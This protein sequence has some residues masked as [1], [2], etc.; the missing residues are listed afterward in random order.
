M[1]RLVPPCGD[2][3]SEVIDAYCASSLNTYIEACNEP[4]KSRLVGLSEELHL[5][6]RSYTAG[7][8]D[9]SQ[10]GR[11]PFPRGAT[12]PLDHGDFLYDRYRRSNDKLTEV[13]A[14]VSRSNAGAC[15]YCGLRL[16]RKPR[17]RAYD[18]DHY[19]PR[20][21]FPEFSI[22]P[23]N[24]VECCDDCNDAKRSDYVDDNGHPLFLH[25]YFADCLCRR[26]LVASVR[27]VE[28]VPSVEFSLDWDGLAM[29]DQRWLQRH[30]DRLEVL[31]RLADEVTPELV[32]MIQNSVGRPIVE[33]RSL[34]STI[35]TEGLRV[36]PN[37]PRHVAIAGLAASGDLSDLVE[38]AARSLHLLRTEAV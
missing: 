30:V 7:R 11:S 22:H 6:Y 16:R 3:A 35:S 31:P 34:L 15:P 36:R 14:A 38:S 27:A 17:E 26:L 18:S 37:D 2:G 23:L 32:T 21:V 4:A 8:G 24:L 33:T 5:R 25:P 10:V 19:L 12:P 13:F 20:S 28:S 29:S 1:I 9:P